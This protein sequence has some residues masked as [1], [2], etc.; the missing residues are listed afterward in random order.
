[1]M[2]HTPLNSQVPSRR[3]FI[4]LMG[5]GIA[6]HMAD[7]PYRAD[8]SIKL[9]FAFSA[10]VS[11]DPALELGPTGHGQR[12]IIPIIGGK[13]NGPGFQGVVLPGGADWQIVRQDKVAEL[14]A[15]YTLKTDD[16][17]L[18][19]ISNKGYRHGPTE[20]LTKISRGEEVDPTQY[21]FKTAAT[22]ETSAEK[23][24][25]LTRTIIIATAERKKDKVLIDF[26]KV[27]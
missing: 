10:E 9:D 24:Q 1:M 11:L 17:A 4:S 23:Y 2:N 22:F 14:D 3:E 19:Y 25:W 5:L 6:A 20:I 12:R 7:A 21:Y 13:F 27:I 26:Y 15:R 16:G 8:M 18:I